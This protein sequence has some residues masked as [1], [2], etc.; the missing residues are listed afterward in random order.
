[1]WAA[2]TVDKLVASRGD[3]MAVLREPKWVDGRVLSWVEP[4]ASSW[5]VRWVSR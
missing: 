4:K 2:P 3:S 1:M 5:V